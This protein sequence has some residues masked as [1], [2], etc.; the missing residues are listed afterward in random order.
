[1]LSFINVSK[2][3]R[4]IKKRVKIHCLLMLNTRTSTRHLSKITG[5]PKTVLYIDLT[6]RAERYYPKLY[7]KVR[8]VLEKNKYENKYEKTDASEIEKMYKKLKRKIFF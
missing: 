2:E 3:E 6:E 7:V 4:M 5:T 1:M 8:K